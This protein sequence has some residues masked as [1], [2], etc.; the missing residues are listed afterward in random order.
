MR[1]RSL[2][3]AIAAALSLP[4]Y[5][6][7]TEPSDDAVPGA[8]S[9]GT[10]AIPLTYVRAN[11]RF[12]IGIDDEG[13]FS[14]EILQV[15]GYNGAQA[16]LAEG[17]FGRAGSGGAKLAY[18]WLWGSSAREAIDDPDSVYVTKGFLAYDRNEWEDDKLTLGFGLERKDVFGSLYYMRGLSDERPIATRLV[19][20]TQ[21]ITGTDNGRP[22][23]QDR[24]TDTL[25]T[26]Y[27]EA[28][29]HG[30]G[31]RAGRFFEDDLWRLR[32][33]VDYEKGDFSSDQLTG[34]L[35]VDK[36]FE[37]TGHS[38]SLELQHLSRDGDFI[39]DDNDTRVG[40]FY[41]YEWG[42]SFRPAV[43]ENQGQAPA[44][45]PVEERIVV[46]EPKIVRNEI[47]LS[48]DAFFD[49]DKSELRPETKAELDALIERIRREKLGSPISIVGHTCS[50]GTDAYNQGLSERRA[51]AVRQYFLDSGI[52]E[53][54]IV[55]G[56]G[57]MEPEFPNDNRENR[58][59]NRRVD[60]DFVT[61]EDQT[62]PG[63][64]TKVSEGTT[65]ATWTKQEINVPAGWVERALKNIPEHKRQVDV[66]QY[67]ELTSTTTRDGPRTFLNRPPVAGNDTATVA[68]NAQGTLINVLANDSD[69]DNNPLTVTSV[70]QP[71]NGQVQNV[72]NGVV[73]TPS[74]NFT[75][76]TT[77]N[78]TISDGQGGTATATVTVTVAD[79]APTA[80]D[81]AAN[82]ARNTAVDVNV[83]ANDRDPEG[84][85]LTITTVTQPANGRAEIVGTQIRYTP[86]Q[87]F[88]GT[89]RFT[90]TIRDAAGNTATANV[91]IT[92]ANAAP[93][94][95]DDAATTQAGVPVTIDV[96]ANDRDPDNDALTIAA[97]G[98]VAN[99]T[100]RI[101]GNRVVYTANAGF[102]GTE[103]FTYTV[104]DEFGAT[105]TAT[106][107]VTVA[108]NRAPTANADSASTTKAN[109]VSINVLA[110]DT[111]PEGDTLTVTRIVSQPTL[112]R[113]EVGANGTVLYTHNPGPV[114]VD[115]FTYEIS[116]GRGNLSVGTV[117]VTII[118]VPNP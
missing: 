26:T 111:D 63:E 60:I 37:N 56:K 41:R 75:G 73:F 44:Q 38:V 99:G 25:F 33:G 82:T 57:E 55:D 65:N 49:F 15:L 113:A 14:G 21:T 90:Y 100:A 81:D 97:L 86:N 43:W 2:S 28:W 66:Y 77:F 87:R 5:A 70:T 24:F 95:A 79:A 4:V 39:V 64:E 58:R 11:T 1:L 10:Q 71:A 31:I 23:T 89:D 118:R 78:Y 74:Q 22:F 115:T 27:E 30:F 102:N 110:N 104:R 85:T 19:T 8:S 47:K 53:E 13:D 109:S 96:L 91:T 35:G 107:R 101:E 84:G 62:I 54:L 114:G 105:A 93:I 29:D 92:V 117:S 9:T 72:G 106:V 40:L 17:W 51:A 34:S 18:N 45:A 52:I 83:L 59:K 46:S 6:Q 50:I 103:S 48:S 98:A 116:D 16:F 7:Q 108:A 32:G 68:R 88:A 112:G 36:Y 20:T 3:L 61:I 80:A 42:Q 94:A 12:S 67:E 76:T 69:P